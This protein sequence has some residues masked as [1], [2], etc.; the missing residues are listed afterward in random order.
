MMKSTMISVQKNVKQTKKLA[1][2]MSHKNSILKYS[3]WPKHQYIRD[4]VCPDGGE[5]VFEDKSLREIFRYLLKEHRIV[6]VAG[7]FEIW[8]CLVLS[9]NYLHKNIKGM[10]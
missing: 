1:F 5:C 4:R 2:V 10:A 3:A 8:F 7:H 9:V 6:D